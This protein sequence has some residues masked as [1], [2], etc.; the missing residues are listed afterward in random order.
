MN[1]LGSGYSENEWS[2]VQW[3]SV[4]S[5]S[6]EDGLQQWGYITNNILIFYHGLLTI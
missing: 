4:K 3:E 6:K 2:A 1:G 5:V